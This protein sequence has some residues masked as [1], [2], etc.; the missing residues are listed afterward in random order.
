MTNNLLFVC[1]ADGVLTN[2][3]ILVT[4]YGMHRIFNL[5][6]V[7]AFSQLK[8]VGHE[9][10]ILTGSPNKYTKR[11]GE[12]YEIPVHVTNDKMMYL[13]NKFPEYFGTD[14]IVSFG[15]DTA[16]I[17]M[18]RC[19]T[20]TGCPRDAWINVYKYVAQRAI[21]KPSTGYP[22]TRAGGEGAFREFIEYFLSHFWS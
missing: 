17:E 4:G 22:A 21:E 8:K 9:A 5:Y 7:E 2:N 19:S 11:F 14:S 15:N 10:I 13:A 20:F 18:M 16:D 12:Y 6:D 1:D 3:T